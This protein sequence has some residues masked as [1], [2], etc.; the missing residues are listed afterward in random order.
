[1]MKGVIFVSA[2]V[3]GLALATY[4]RTVGA[5]TSK[6]GLVA[7]TCAAVAGAGSLIQGIVTVGRMF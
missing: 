6:T 5:N 2:G 3:G 4:L 7:T 1:M